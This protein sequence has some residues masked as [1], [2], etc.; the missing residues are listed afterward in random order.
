MQLTQ[1]L[2]PKVR[3]GPHAERKTPHA[4]HHPLL[5]LTSVMPG[6]AHQ[7][8]VTICGIAQGHHLLL[9]ITQRLHLD[10]SKFIVPKEHKYVQWYMEKHSVVCA[11][12]LP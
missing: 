11:W 10:R 8:G 9:A 2:L 6:K 1:R 4:V 3:I 12:S 7:D 5:A